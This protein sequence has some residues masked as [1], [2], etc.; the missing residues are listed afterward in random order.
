ML[1]VGHTAV[2]FDYPLLIRAAFDAV[3][4]ATTTSPKLTDLQ[5]IVDITQKLFTIVAIIVGGAWTYL[6]YFKGRTFRMRL[7]PS[8]TGVVS[9]SDGANQLIVSVSLKNVGLSKIGIEQTG[10]AL[11]VFAY[12]EPIYP[13]TS[14]QS[15]SW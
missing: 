14:I 7:E 11:E 3:T 13:L 12:E 2:Q 6:N 8:V 10:S 4:M 1:R 9:T 15:A 5:K